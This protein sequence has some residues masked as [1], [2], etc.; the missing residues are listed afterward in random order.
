MMIRTFVLLIIIS[1]GLFAA[2]VESDFPWQSWGKEAFEQARKEDKFV[3]L[4]L[5]AWWCHPC[6]QMN[7]ITYDDPAVRELIAKKFI[8]VF[9]DQDG[10][11]DISQRFERWGWP[12]TII[13]AADGTEIVKLK[14]FY[15][16][17]FFMPILQA[18]IDDPSPV[19]YGRMQGPERAV[20]Q[21]IQLNDEQRRVIVDFM[22]KMYDDTHGGWGRNSKFVHGPTFDYALEQTA[23]NSFDEKRAR[24]TIDGLIAMVDK[25][26]G[27][28]SQISLAMDWNKG[29]EE[30]PMF[31]QLA[32]LQAFSLA[33]SLW[34][35]PRYLHAAQRVSD[36]LRNTMSAE[37]GGFYT[38][39]GAHNFNPGVD[40]R[41]YARENGQAILALTHLYNVTGDSALLEFIERQA[42]WVLDNRSLDSGGF[43]HDRVDQGGP[44]LVDSL[45][46]GRAMLALYQSGAKRD[47][48]VRARN[49]ADFIA[50]NFIDADTGGFIAAVRP[51]GDFM[52]KA[53]KNKDDNVAATRFFNRLY[54]Y[55]GDKRYTEIAR[56]A[57][58]Y[59]TSDHVLDAYWFLPGV[60]QAEYELSN[61]PVHITV[62]GHKDDPQ[63]AR[64]HTAALAYP[65]NY[66]RA[67]WWDKREGPLPNDDVS[68]PQLTRAA[69]F[70]CT[71]SVCSSPVYNREDLAA[72]VLRLM[73][74][75]R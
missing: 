19:N 53:V 7:T 42:Q 29:L 10:R 62:V 65:T 71:D 56:N 13:F 47:W 37:D 21:T 1:P 23:I 2:P 52:T 8:P 59:L 12:A 4:S 44:Y 55:T 34:Q 20:S 17:K 15:S 9:V 67:E 41:R 18:T 31:A 39:T 48:L 33:Y 73:P 25:D 45:S 69:A 75:S 22:N 49:T 27:G 60:L 63:A 72:A 66:K 36:F 24:Q 46:M 64:L 51:A 54:Y 38:S 35:E 68:Y 40:R 30:Y 70:A 43:R 50:D 11:P 57:M 5:Q 74:Q 3:L 28:V 26:S 16:P 6:H 14:G 58:G 61:Q 32:G